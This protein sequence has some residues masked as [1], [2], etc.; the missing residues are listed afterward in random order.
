V[1]GAVRDVHCDPW[2]KTRVYMAAG[3]LALKQGDHAGALELYTR[4]HE[5]AQSYG[6][7]G[8]G[9]QSLPRIGLAQLGLARLGECDVEAAAETFR[10]LEGAVREMQAVGQLT[11]GGLYAEYGLAMVAHQQGDVR[12][13]ERIIREVRAKLGQRTTSN[14][15]LKLIREFELG[16][17]NH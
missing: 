13:A 9:Y 8:R 1:I 11:I 5:A 2:I 15:L 16:Q 17:V 4:Q 14:L 3:D 7:E 12:G 10:E 6:G